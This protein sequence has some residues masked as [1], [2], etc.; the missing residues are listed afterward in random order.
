MPFLFGRERGGVEE[1]AKGHVQ[2]TL[3]EKRAY[4]QLAQYLESIGL[5]RYQRNGKQK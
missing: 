3:R 5:R 4:E 1:V 2:L